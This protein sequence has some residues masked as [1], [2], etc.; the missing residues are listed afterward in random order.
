MTIDLFQAG[1]RLRQLRENLGLTLRDVEAA[2]TRLAS[3][4]GHDEFAVPLSRLSEIET[5]GIVPSLYRLYALALTYR[6]DFRELLTWYGIDLNNAATDLS[7]AEP[8]KSHR[9]DITQMVTTVRIPVRMDP[10]FDLRKTC[11]LGRMIERWGVV[12]LAYL[13]QFE[14][15][16]YSYGYIGS[17]DF[18]MYPILLPSSLVQIDESKN[19]VAEGNWRSEYERPIYF[20]ETRT[21]HVC[22]WCAL[23][24]G[25][26]VLQSHPLSPEPVRVLRHPQ[27]AEVIGQVVGVAMRL[28]ECLPSPA[29]EAPAKLN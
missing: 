10:A 15:T 28:G 11:N 26:I 17:E 29:P 16:D 27:Q 6:V 24:Q 4:Y 1:R 3:K 25:E 9:F 23:R 21:G 19:R 14:N 18:T 2:S 13:A 7:I 12:P 22:S 8:P 20:V 5:K